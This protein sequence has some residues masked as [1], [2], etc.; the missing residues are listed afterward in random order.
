MKINISIN[1]LL[2]WFSDENYGE[3]VAWPKVMT[4]EGSGRI[5]GAQLVGHSGE[6]LIDLFALAMRHGI[7][8]ADLRSTVFAFGFFGRRQEHVVGSITE[9]LTGDYRSCRE[10]ARRCHFAT[11]LSAT[12]GLG[13]V[14]GCVARTQSLNV[15]NALTCSKVA[16]LAGG[17]LALLKAKEATM[18]GSP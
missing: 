2:D 17:M 18:L 13:Q 5:V 7:T 15:R 1:D 16:G 10:P 9:D 11:S 8:A 6:E 3:T 12:S 14:E 4:E